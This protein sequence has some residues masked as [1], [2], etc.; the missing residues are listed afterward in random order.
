[1]DNIIYKK[2][3]KPETIIIIGLLI[4]IICSF[5]NAFFGILPGAD[6]DALTFHESAVNFS[7]GEEDGTFSNIYE[8]LEAGKAYVIILGTLYKLI[9]A[10]FELFAGGILSSITWM[11]SAIIL[12]KILQLNKLNNSYISIALT[13]YSILPFGIIYTSVTLRE[14]YQLLLINLTFYFVIL[15][16]KKLK[17]RYVFGLLVTLFILYF[18]HKAIIFFIAFIISV[19]LI[20]SMDK[21]SKHFRNHKFLTLI[22]FISVTYIYLPYYT[23][24]YSFLTDQVQN[25]K[26]N[27][28]QD[29]RAIYND[30]LRITYERNYFL[31][32]LIYSLI[33]FEF[34][35]YPWR[36][37][38]NVDYILI[39]QNAFKLF[40]FYIIIKKL[41]LSFKLKNL[42]YFIL[43]SIFI[44]LEFL[45]STGTVNWG[46]AAR[47]QVPGYGMLI[48]LSFANIKK[49]K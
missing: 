44:F 35:P 39:A 19:L 9:P 6:H 8:F 46:T 27:H 34:E 41:I 28:N 31:F 49:I 15:I 13:I 25:Y 4:R 20:I 21:I 7:R 30:Q 43:F 22:L 37:T 11:F 26:F 33:Q 17:T 24:F 18:F 38:L 40:L 32:S 48:Y 36:E 45:W 47:H 10:S 2:I 5:A 42:S 12:Y 16:L 29:A 14:A 3:P 1:M 23:D